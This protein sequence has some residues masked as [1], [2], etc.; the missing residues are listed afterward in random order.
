[1]IL[2]YETSTN[3]CS[4]AFLNSKGEIFEKR[5]QGRSVHSDNLFLFTQQLMDE[6]NFII[7]DLDAVLVSNGPGSY[8]GLRIAASAIKGLLF[9]TNT[10]LYAVN[11]LAS[12]AMGCKSEAVNNIHSIIDARRTHV[13]HQSFRFDKILH[14]L[15][16]SDVIEISEFENLLQSEDCVIG[17]GIERIK[18]DALRNIQIFDSSFISAKNLIDLFRLTNAEVYCTKTDPEVLNSNYISSSQVNNSIT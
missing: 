8:T 12:F 3:I 6:H 10:S 14:E 15:S 9:G 11:T 1:M 4:V 2:A 18:E 13:Y 7:T 16:E 17:T 5:I